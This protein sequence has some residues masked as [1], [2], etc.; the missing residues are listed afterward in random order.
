M[1]LAISASPLL[2]AQGGDATTSRLPDWL[3]LSGEVRG[4]TEVTS[5][6]G[7]VAGNDNLRYLHRFRLDTT[8]RFASWLRLNSEFQDSRVAGWQTNTPPASVANSDLRLAYFQIG[9]GDN[10]GW[11]VRAGRQLLVFGSMR[12]LSTS[13]WGNVGP[14]FDGV[15]VSYKKE[16]ADMSWFAVT[17]VKP[18]TGHFDQFRADRKLWGFY[19][20][21]L[22]GKTLGRFEPYVIVKD[23]VTC[24]GENGKTGALV[25]WTMGTRLLGNLGKSTDYEAEIAFQRGRMA[26]DPLSAWAGHWEFGYHIPAIASPRVFAEYNFGSGD[27]DP[28]DGRRQT[29]EQLY[30]TNKWGTADDVAWR[31]IHEPVVGIALTPA[32]KWKYLLQFRDLWLAHRQDSLYGMSGAV[33]ASGRSAT[34]S[35]VGEE[36]DQRVTYQA[37]QRLQLAA[38]YGHLFPGGFL[39]SASPGSSSTTAYLMW[40]FKL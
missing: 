22:P 21:W 7:Y 2:C 30:P 16:R 27:H 38:G 24:V 14:A 26:G 37:S 40:T 31:N 29:F 1:V 20:A 3:K 9:K 39:K 5:A 17:A 19:G 4:R 32:R 23:N 13:N 28:R 8:I 18:V 36:L 25:V 15:R 33:L 34:S 11:G 35:H 12:V 10:T 6:L